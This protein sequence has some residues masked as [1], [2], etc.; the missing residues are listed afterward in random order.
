MCQNLIMHILIDGYNFI[1]QPFS[2]NRFERQSLEAGRYTLI[3]WL[4]EYRRQKNHLITVAFGGWENCQ[5]QE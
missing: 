4:A 5:L 2:L 1:R 3:A